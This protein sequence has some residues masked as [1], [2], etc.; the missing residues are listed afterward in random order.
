MITLVKF[1]TAGSGY[2]DID[3]YAACIAEAERLRRHGQIAHAVSSAP[4]NESI[5]PSLRKLPVQLDDYVPGNSDE[6]ILVDVSKESYFDPIVKNGTIIEVIDHHPGQKAY[7]SARPEV[8]TDIELIGAACTQIF[9]RWQRDD[10]L[11][12][13]NPAI[14]QL[15]AA[16]ILDNT[17]NLKAGMTTSRDVTAYQALQT[18]GNLPL[19]FAQAYFDECQQ[20]ID[21]K[22]E[23]ALRNDTK[24]MEE[25]PRLPHILGQLTAWDAKRYLEDEQ[26]VIAKVLGQLGD[27]WA[28]NLISISE[29]KSYLVSTSPSGQKKLE[30]LLGVVFNDGVAITDR[31]WLRKELLHA[32]L[33]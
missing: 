27:D 11:Q 17:L 32:A 7:W 31:L 21:Q 9:E 13:M 14:A 8:K 15:L 6:F 33:N 25:A 19:E 26:S 29:G 1:V 20:A 22:F 2:M 5:P 10:L 4:L 16:G 3:A 18:I 23:V 24:S 30:H 12:R 28:L